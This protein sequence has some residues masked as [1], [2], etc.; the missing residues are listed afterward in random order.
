MSGSRTYL[1]TGS[2]LPPRKQR[3]RPSEA[4]LIAFV[5]QQ[6]AQGITPSIGAIRQHMGYRSTTSVKDLVRKLR[7][8]GQLSQLPRWKVAA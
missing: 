6:V 2:R 4:R 1:H 3:P 7:A 8:R 5:E